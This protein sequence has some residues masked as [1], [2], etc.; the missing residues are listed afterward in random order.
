[1]LCWR[2]HCST[3]PRC[4]TQSF[5]KGCVTLKHYKRQQTPRVLP[6]SSYGCNTAAQ[7]LWFRVVTNHII[8]QQCF[9]QRRRAPLPLSADAVASLPVTDVAN[10]QS[11][12]GAVLDWTDGEVQL[13]REVQDSSG[14]DSSDRHNKL[15]PFCDAGELVEIILQGKK[16]SQHSAFS[17]IP[18]QKKNCCF[19]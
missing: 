1:M 17:T 10:Q 11:F 18:W 3:K 19:L 8:M 7:M 2:H 14:T 5:I 12:L 4:S 9:A 15:F 13:V 6:V 16:Q